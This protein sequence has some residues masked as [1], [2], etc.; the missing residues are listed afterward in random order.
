M[1]NFYSSSGNS[2]IERK[3]GWIPDIPDIRDKKL[4]FSDHHVNQIKSKVDL[5]KNFGN[6]YDQ[7][8]L[9]SCTANAICGAFVFDQ[10]RQNFPKFD[11][12]R[13]FLYY[14]EREKD[15]TV[16][17]DSGSSIRN[18]IKSVNKCGLCKESYWPYQIGYFT[19]KP[20]YK[21]YDESKFHRGV[22]YKRINND[23]ESLRA[24]LS[25]GNPIIFGFAVYDSFEDVTAW[26]PKSDEMP[27]PNPNKEKLLGGHAV[28]VV[29]YT[30]KRKCFLV[31]N[32]WGNEWGMSG[33][34]LM[35]YKFIT[36]ELC[37][38][39]WVLET[40]SSD[41]KI[42][43]NNKLSIEK[44]S[45]SEVVVKNI[46]YEKKKKKKKKKSKKKN[47]IREEN[48]SD[49]ICADIQPCEQDIKTVKIEVPEKKEKSRKCLIRDD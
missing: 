19:T 29:G 27:M 47:N 12:S 20:P 49:S 36:S 3:Y 4:K 14:N 8:S 13:L 21:C 9:G 40:V 44:D 45:Y 25:L 15:G 7:G 23:L 28:V 43:E 17:I 26:D 48:D 31:R 2:D 1:G 30:N 37:S 10:K 41:E 32:S 46:D 18:G 24:C 35:S 22:R 11:P 5:R 39:F 42:V 34:F 33:Y 38:D 16:G 6:V